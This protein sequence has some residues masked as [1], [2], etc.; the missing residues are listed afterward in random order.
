MLSWAGDGPPVTVGV[1]GPMRGGVVAGDFLAGVGELVRPRPDRWFDDPVGWASEVVDGL[2]LTE[3]Q[4]RALRELGAHGRLSVRSLH[5]AGKTTFAAVAVLWFAT[6][7]DR[8]GVDWKAITTASAWRQV[9][10]YL[11]PE[12]HKWA[13]KIRWEKLGRRPWS[14]DEL[15]VLS[16]KLGS[17]EAFAVVSDDHEKLEGAHA[18]HLLFVFDEAKAIPAK[19]FDAI[20]GAFSGTGVVF[21]LSI[22][23]P[24]EPQGRFFQIQ[25]RAKGYEDWHVLRWL[26]ESVVSAGRVDPV[27]VANRERQWGRDSALFQNRVLGEFATHDEDGV[28]PL[29]W[30][31]AAQERWGEFHVAC[32]DPENP[33]HK[34]DPGEFVAVGVDPARSGPDKTA[35]ALR[36]D[37]QIYSLRTA[38]KLGTTETV[39]RTRAILEAN[40]GKAVV[41]V[42]GIGAGVVDQLRDD[43][44]K[45]ISGSV[46]AFNAAEATSLKDRSGELGFVNCRSAAWWML[47]ERLEDGTIMLPPDD[48]LTGDLTAP[49]WR[50]SSAGKIQVESKD[51]IRKRLGRSTD[52]ADA[53]IQA[54]WVDTLTVRLVVGVPLGIGNESYWRAAG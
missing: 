38:S 25:S 21:V 45:N 28:I 43:P 52:V 20:E 41:D 29:A 4:C 6:T 27:W 8:A 34:C 46:V 9:T 17:G 49:R 11:W 19:T 32:G 22:S 44:Q 16:I 36:H 1:R 40:G 37:N 15:R 50:M 10:K 33:K 39:G 35:W 53:V 24:G 48:L 2:V 14:R 31:E 42:I 5:G 3:Y 13:R 12:V 23:T 7:R 47:R 30:V 51:D 26:L 54:F 18:D